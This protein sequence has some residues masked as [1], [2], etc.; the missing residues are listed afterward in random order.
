MKPA[1]GYRTE[2]PVQ[3]EIRNDLAGDV[4]LFRAN[5]GRGWTGSEVIT[6]ANGDKL[7]RNPRVFDTGL[8]AGF[9]DLFGFRPVVVTPDM[10]GQTLAVFVA[11]DAKSK[12]GRASDKQQNF[13][14]A[15]NNNGGR[16]GFASSVEHARNIV[17]GT[18][19]SYERSGIRTTSRTNRN[20]K[21]GEGTP[22]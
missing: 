7:I 3:N 18:G 6:L 17:N 12:D 19:G 14:N 9:T 2:H 15:V 22:V 16:A 5:V 10:V 20:R 21:P 13:V 8:P 1:G 4:F 11:I